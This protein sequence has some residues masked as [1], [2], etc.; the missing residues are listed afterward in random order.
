MS[1]WTRRARKYRGK[2]GLDAHRVLEEDGRNLVHSLNLLEAFLD[3]RLP[4]ILTSSRLR[5]LGVK[6]CPFRFIGFGCAYSSFL[7]AK[8][9]RWPVLQ[10]AQQPSMDR[11]SGGAA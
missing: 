8:L 4:F 9:R 2:E 6:N 3:G 5:Q 1:A 10:S 7:P 11:F